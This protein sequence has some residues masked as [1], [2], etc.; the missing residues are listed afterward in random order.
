MNGTVS[1]EVDVRSP[2]GRVWHAL[3]D[4]RAMSAWALFTVEDFQPVV[5]YRIRFRVPQVPGWEGTITGQV[6]EAEE[7][8][9]LSYTWEGGPAP[10]AVHTTVTWTLTEVRPGF[11][12]LHMEQRGFDPVAKE[13]IGGA[14]YGWTQMTRQLQAVLEA[15]AGE[16]AGETP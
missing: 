8:H 11:T 7:P 3:T 1:V 2:I 4:A 6:L 15:P 12:W 13:A 16:R 14:H 5:G 9:R 10:F